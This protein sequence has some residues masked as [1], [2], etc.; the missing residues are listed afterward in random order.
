MNDH[1]QTK[2]PNS[3]DSS[4]WCRFIASW[5][6]LPITSIK[7][8]GSRKEYHHAFTSSGRAGYTA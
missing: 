3:Y 2:W 4:G 7:L 8:S 5:A 6:I 1:F